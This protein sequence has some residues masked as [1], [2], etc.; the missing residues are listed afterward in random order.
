MEPIDGL[1]SINK[2][3]FIHFTEFATVRYWFRLNEHVPYD[4]YFSFTF[5]YN[6]AV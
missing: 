4:F 1:K 6:S 5:V 2:V 3:K